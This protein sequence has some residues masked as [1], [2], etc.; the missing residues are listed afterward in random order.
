MTMTRSGILQLH[1][2]TLDSSIGG[3]VEKESLTLP[4]WQFA[5]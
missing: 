3:D 4:Q 2:M 5:V 1:E